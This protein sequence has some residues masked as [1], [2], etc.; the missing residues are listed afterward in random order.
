[1]YYDGQFDDSRMCVAL[2]C[3]AAMAG[4]AVT[5]YT[6]VSHHPLGWSWSGSGG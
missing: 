5:N 3:S 2:A 6:Q 1:V 4:G